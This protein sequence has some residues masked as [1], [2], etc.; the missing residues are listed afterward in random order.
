MSE[1]KSYSL[2]HCKCFELPH[3]APYLNYINA[4]SIKKSEP[5]KF[6]NLH[7]ITRSLHVTWNR[8]LYCSAG[9][10]IKC[11]SARTYS[12]NLIIWRTQNR[13]KTQFL[14]RETRASRRSRLCRRQLIISSS[15]WQISTS[16]PLLQIQFPHRAICRLFTPLAAQ[17][18][19]AIFFSR[20]A[21]EVRECVGGVRER[22]QKNDGAKGGSAALKI[23]VVLDGHWF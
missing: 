14:Q 20:G 16:H 4:S 9:A 8:F 13:I 7:Q 2:T 12:S 6:I 17:R 21:R 22:K 5:Y 15:L 10:P 11:D 23:N 3:L 18:R 19:I 1:N